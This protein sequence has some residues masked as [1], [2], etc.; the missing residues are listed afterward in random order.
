MSPVVF[1]YIYGTN[2]TDTIH[3]ADKIIGDQPGA[4]NYFIILFQ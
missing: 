1:I 2:R 3:P 4:T